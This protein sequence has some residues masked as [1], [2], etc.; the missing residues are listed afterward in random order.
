MRFATRTFWW[1]FAPFAVLLAA[2]FWAVRLAVTSAV[3]EEL[4]GSVRQSQVLAASDR[5]RNERQNQRI[6]RVVAENPALKAGLELLMLER[7]SREEARRTVEDQLSEICDALGIDFLVVSGLRGEPLAGIMHYADGYRGMNLDGLRLPQ[8]GFYME[9]GGVY[10]TTSVPINQ[11]NEMVGTLAVGERFDLASMA[12]DAVLMREGMVVGETVGRLQ[13][14]EI[15]KALTD[16]RSQA[17]CEV[18]VAGESYLSLPMDT[19]GRE[20]IPVVKDGFSLRSLQSIDAATAPLLAS[21]RTVFIVAGLTAL[22]AAFVVSYLSSRSIVRPLASLVKLL[23]TSAKSGELPVFPEHSGSTEE[24]RELSEGFNHAGAAIRMARG[25]LLKAYIEFTGSLASALDARDGYTAGHSR[26]VCE[27]SCQIGRAMNLSADDLEVIRVGALLHDIGKIGIADRV[28][29]KP[30]KL[31]PE[32]NALIQRHPVIGRHI[33]EGVHG[34]EPYLPVIE[35]HH[36]NWDGSGYPHGLK[37]ESTPLVARI[38]KVAD[39]YDAM[40]SDRPYRKGTSHEDALRILKE[41]VGTQLDAAV[42]AAFTG[43]ANFQPLRG[44]SADEDSLR[45]LAGAVED[46]RKPVAAVVEDQAV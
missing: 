3:R 24:I 32:E 29:Q 15:E 34:F 17:E 25:Q 44:T 2:N 8:T 4:R 9:E 7:N 28:L 43:L 37:A 18:E 46:E 30:G 10:Q 31:T 12:R 20:S 36:E 21:L 5:L 42:V 35:L 11:G 26:R 27:Y 14:P 40:T 41:N 33:L 13:P 45:N 19:A 6:L 22:T 1:S 23:R 16:C 39:A 38:V